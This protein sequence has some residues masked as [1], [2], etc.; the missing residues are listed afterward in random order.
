MVQ[1]ASRDVQMAHH[2]D[3]KIKHPD[4]PPKF[5]KFSELLSDT[6]T[7]DRQDAQVCRPDLRAKKSDSY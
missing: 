3:G 5:E 1:T 2:L 4:G 7:V 6:E